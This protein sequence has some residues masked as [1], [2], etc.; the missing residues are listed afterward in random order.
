MKTGTIKSLSL[1]LS[2]SLL[3]PVLFSACA[4]SKPGKRTAIGTGVG[5]AAGAGAGAAIGAMTGDVKKGAAI[6][7]A[8]GAVLGG[9]F[10]YHLDQQAKE[11]AEVAETKRTEEGIITTLK[12]NILFDSNSATLKPEAM[13]AI[14]Q[15]S[16]IIKKYP[17]DYV[18]V[19]GYTDEVGSAAH[20]Q[21]LSEQRAKTVR[22]AMISKGV[23]AQSAEA[24]GMGESNPVGD[25]KTEAGRAKNRRVELQI[26]MKQ[27][28]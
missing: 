24:V 25:N 2:I 9:G 3:S 22:L 27:A 6:G 26:T 19:A 12:N 16:D 5:A 1:L 23:P 11:L 28:Q 15:L 20:N 4:A 21:Q 13:D 10:G 7:A 17:E 14:G 8:A 18:I